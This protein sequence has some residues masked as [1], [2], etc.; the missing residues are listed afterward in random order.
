MVKKWGKNSTRWSKS[1]YGDLWVKGYLFTQKARII[2]NL[3]IRR[4]ECLSSG[5]RKALCSSDP[6][7]GDFSH[8]H[9]NVVPFRINIRSYTYYEVRL[10]R[11][12]K[13]ILSPKCF[14][15]SSMLAELSI[16]GL[17]L[18]VEDARCSSNC[19]LSHVSFEGFEI[20]SLMFR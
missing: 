16:N 1:I 11:Y 4:F 7:Y 12:L 6:H 10:H 19:R 9:L 18:W 5:T 17:E 2:W 15:C 14:C 13:S 3:I 20:E 8:S